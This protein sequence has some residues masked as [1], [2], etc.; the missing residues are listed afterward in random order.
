MILIAALTAW[1][2][3]VFFFVVLCRAAASADGRDIASTE[4]YPTVPTGASR[5]DASGRMPRED[6]SAPALQDRPAAY[7]PPPRVRGVRGH[8]ERYAAEP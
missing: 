2:I 1:L 7:S 6:R 5:R 3:L 8:A 4:R